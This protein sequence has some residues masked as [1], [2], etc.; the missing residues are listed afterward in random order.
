MGSGEMP[1]EPGDSWFS[2]K[3]IEVQPRGR[4]AAVEHWMGEGPYPVTELN[5]TPKATHTAA[6]VRP[7]G[8]SFTVKRETAQT[9]R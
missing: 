5:Q 1:I 9:R 2:P 3:C 6:G 7:W 8:I 4:V